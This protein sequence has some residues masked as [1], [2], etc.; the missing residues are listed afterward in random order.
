VHL[1][2]SLHQ[3]LTPQCIYAVLSRV[4]FGPDADLEKHKQLGAL[5]DM[6]RLQRQVSYFGDQEGVDGLRTY[7]GEDEISRTV[8]GML[9]DDRLEPYIP[10]RPFRDWAGVEDDGFR[11]L[12][13]KLMNLDPAKRITAERALVHAWFGDV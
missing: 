2:H 7:L 3:K 11:D 9:W 4:I 5:P 13:L 1:L 6:I 8:L 12:V 10:Y